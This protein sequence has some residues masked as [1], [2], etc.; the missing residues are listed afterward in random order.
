MGSGEASSDAPCAAAEV[1]GALSEA[2]F[3]VPRP[4]E[5]RV[6]AIDGTSNSLGA[7]R[8]RVGAQWPQEDLESRMRR[9]PCSFRGASGIAR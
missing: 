2:I 7:G 1:L 8:G 9:G 3:R 5:E 4:A 6:R